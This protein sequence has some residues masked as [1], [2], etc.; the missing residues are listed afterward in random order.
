MIMIYHVFR[1]LFLVGIRI[2]AIRNTKALH[3]IDGRKSWRKRLKN[4]WNLSP[5]EKV[6]WM[7]C[8]SVGEFEQGRPLLEAIRKQNPTIKLLLTFFSPS[9][10]NMHKK[11]EGVDY[12]S[13]LPF[14]GKNNARDFIDIIR[15][16]LV[17]FVKYEFWYFYL[18]TLK[19]KQIPVILASGL[20][21][22]SQPFFQTWGSFHRHML[23][24]FTR[25]FVQNEES[26]RLLQSIHLHQQTEMTGDTRFDRVA[27]I[28]TQPFSFPVLES[29]ANEKI[30]IAGSTW[31]ED[32]KLLLDWHQRQQDWK[33]IIVP[34]EVSA[35]HISGLKAMFPSSIT[36]SEQSM[37][38][39]LSSTRVLIIDQMG[40]LSK[41][42][43]YASLCYIGGGLN[44]SG[45]HN[46]LEA[47][48]Y[49]K[50]VVTGPFIEKFSESV[51]LK[52][53]GGSFIVR[54]GSDL[55]D[56]TTKEETCI[57]AGKIAGRFVQMHRGATKKMIDWLVNHQ[58]NLLLTKA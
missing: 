22:K 45:H 36:L 55:F 24:C 23:G 38:Q 18:T 41:L 48:V 40:L 2:A 42:Y 47:A 16:T 52:K 1:F 54:N 43:R 33:L 57:N 28:A 5:Q 17:I 19:N 56:I 10:L 25:L 53:A 15:P 39:P 44:K 51:S 14:D 49:G 9:G 6:I 21:R 4:E 29:F 20:F 34:H 27:E 58:P 32:E 37:A 8:A 3:W 35:S 50:A 26:V 13:Y 31:P 11:F 30:L 7:H 12:V 46:I